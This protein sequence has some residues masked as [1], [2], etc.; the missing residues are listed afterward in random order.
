MIS[1]IVPTLD[2]PSALVKLLASISTQNFPL[3]DIEILVVFNT[4]PTSTTHLP[5][6]TDQSPR[7]IYLIAPEPGVNAARNTGLMAAQGDILLFLDDDTIMQDV[8][9]LQKLSQYHLQFPNQLSIGGPY[10]LPW[11][12][13]QGHYWQWA[14]HLIIDEWMRSQQTDHFHYR[15]LLGGNA[16]YKRKV[17]ENGLRFTPGIKYGGSETLLNEKIFELYGPHLFLSDLSIGH[18]SSLSL[19]SFIKKAYLQGRGSALHKKI[20]PQRLEISPLKTVNSWAH[21]IYDFVFSIG[22]RTSIFERNTPIVSLLEELLARMC[23]PF[24]NSA[25]DIKAAYQYAKDRQ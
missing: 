16:S 21:T 5:Q 18:V 4:P 9:Y 2:R 10:N 6:T 1:I 20:R 14:Y 13:P 25:R 8:N 17:F 15:T 12:R 3:N 11:E 23:R 19:W 7:T 22:Y 24:R